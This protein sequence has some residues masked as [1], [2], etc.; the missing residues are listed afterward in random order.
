MTLTLG[1]GPFGPG[2]G[3][4]SFGPPPEDWWYVEQW[5]RRMRAV[6]AGRTVLDSRRGKVLYRRGEPPRH[7]FP[8]ADV[9]TDLLVPADRDRTD[10]GPEC[11]SVVVGDHTAPEAVTG[12]PVKHP[13]APPLD[14]HVTIDFGAMDR[15][16]EEDEPLYAGPR[17]P[18]HRV[19]VRASSRH[20]LVRHRDV[21]VA[22]TRRPKLLFETGLP[23][24]YY[25][26]FAD[27]DLGLLERSG[28]VSECPYKGDGQHWHL[29][30]GGVRVPDAAWS[31][32]HPRPEA[33]AAAEHICFYGDKVH[34]EVDGERI[35]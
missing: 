27:V 8:L 30:A 16:F 29:V 19:D 35:R 17:D 33:L 18:Y 25:L 12:P 20:V 3:E 9:H 13:D 1:S 26:P 5:P 4:F 7:W 23:V 32:P 28:T 14:D 11:W 22:E 24:R 21:P 31:L 2:S 15:W 34:V 6:L 10:E